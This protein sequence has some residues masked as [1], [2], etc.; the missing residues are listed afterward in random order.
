MRQRTSIMRRVFDGEE[1]SDDLATADREVD[2]EVERCVGIAQPL[3]TS[4]VFLCS[5]DNDRIMCSKGNTRP[6]PYLCSPIELHVTFTP[7]LYA[8][9]G[10]GR[11]GI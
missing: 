9:S 5:S 10:K 11:S 8:A 1:E 3:V 2:V 7:S 6:F 4:L